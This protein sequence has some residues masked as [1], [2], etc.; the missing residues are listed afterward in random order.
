MPI[1]S[2]IAHTHFHYGI[3][4]RIYRTGV[5]SIW[6]RTNSLT[7]AFRR[8]YDQ[9]RTACS[10]WNYVSCMN[11]LYN[12]KPSRFLTGCFNSV[13]VFVARPTTSH[14]LT[15]S[16]HHI[17]IYFDTLVLCGCGC[18]G[19]GWQDTLH[20]NNLNYTN[21]RFDRAPVVRVVPTRDGNNGEPQDTKDPS[22]P[23]YYTLSPSTKFF[24]IAPSQKK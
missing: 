12:K 21:I 1:V 24:G 9:H 4:F 16:Y 11:G 14:P 8:R 10:F 15:R 5:L 17:H 22:I 23:W 13:L 3:V 7:R 2:A 20:K 19:G 6:H 18:N